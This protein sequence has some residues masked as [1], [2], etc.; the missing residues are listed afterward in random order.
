MCTPQKCGSREKLKFARMSQL[1]PPPTPTRDYSRE[2]DSDSD[3]SE[4]SA[5][6]SLSYTLLLASLYS[7]KIRNIFEKL[8]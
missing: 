7:H 4:D 6:A 1:L 3:V 8:Y 2:D 5:G